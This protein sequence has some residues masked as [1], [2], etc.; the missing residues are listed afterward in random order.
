MYLPREGT[1]CLFGTF[2]LI[3]NVKK[4]LSVLAYMGGGSQNQRNCVYIIL[5]CTFKEK[6][7]NNYFKTMCTIKNINYMQTWTF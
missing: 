4:V 7:F 2:N 6:H 3:K 5:E 1:L